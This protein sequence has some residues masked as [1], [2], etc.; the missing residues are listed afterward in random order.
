MADP[1]SALLGAI[2]G[3]A[4]DSNSASAWAALEKQLAEWHEPHDGGAVSTDYVDD[5]LGR[6]LSEKVVE[7]IFHLTQ[8]EPEPRSRRSI[9]LARG[10]WERLV[11]A[12]ESAAIV[13]Q[14]RRNR[15]AG[16]GPTSPCSDAASP[17][18]RV[19]TLSPPPKCK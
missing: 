2:R 9:L 18:F 14:I 17:S 6:I 19:G 8:L 1:L 13:A 7:S 4:F 15:R 3:A 11:V 12:I 16:M 5:Q 10:L